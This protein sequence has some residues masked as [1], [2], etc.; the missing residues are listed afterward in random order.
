MLIAGDTACPSMV[1]EPFKLKKGKHITCTIYNDDNFVE[2]ETGGD[3]IIFHRNTIEFMYNGPNDG[4]M[5]P[6][7]GITDIMGNPFNCS[8]GPCIELDSMASDVF[9]VHDSS[10]NKL[11][12]L[13]VFNVFPLD[14]SNN[15]SAETDRCVVK[16]LLPGPIE[17]TLSFSFQCELI[18]GQFV[19]GPDSSLGKYRINYAVIDTLVVI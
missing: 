18:E 5:D 17:G 2:G 11:T 14:V 6:L 1:D 7:V 19:D 13:V 16:T 10:I 4:V 9:I 12:S 15:Q 8:S 3:G